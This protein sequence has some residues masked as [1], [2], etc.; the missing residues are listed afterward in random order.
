[1]AIEVAKL[2]WELQWLRALRCVLI[3]C[4]VLSTFT[5]F[6]PRLRTS[7]NPRYNSA[8][9]PL[10]NMN[11]YVFME[12]SSTSTGECIGQVLVLVKFLSLIYVQL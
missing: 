1:M 9:A 3:Y 11:H 8:L 6:E 12:K 5:R 2:S 4:L 10:S 7:Y